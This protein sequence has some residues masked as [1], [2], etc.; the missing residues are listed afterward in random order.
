MAFQK[1]KLLRNLQSEI[2]RPMR[3]TQKPLAP[4]LMAAPGKLT[5]I[6]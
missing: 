6:Y 2:G 5:R 1:T 4:G 3:F